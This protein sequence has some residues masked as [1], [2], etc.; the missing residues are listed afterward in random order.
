M[1]WT[2]SL[3]VTLATAALLAMAVFLLTAVK[4]QAQTGIESL[5]GALNGSEL[6]PGNLESNAGELANDAANRVPTNMLDVPDQVTE[7]LPGGVP[8]GLDDLP[9]DVGQPQMVDTPDAPTGGGAQMVETPDAPTSE[10]AQMV[11]TPDAPSGGGQTAQAP[12]AAST[13]TGGEV[14]SA[15]A[16]PSDVS[17]QPSA[18]VTDLPDTGGAQLLS[19]LF[20]TLFVGL[21]FAGFM[22]VRFVG[23]TAR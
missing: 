4:S 19:M 5:E 12:E 8:G 21:G 7:P 11:E 17:A 20:A 10:G 18:V 3:A 13:D 9:I 16:A 15:S 23:C 6:V 1:R 2:Q 22:A 14:A